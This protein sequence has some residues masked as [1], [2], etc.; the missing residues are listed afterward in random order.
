MEAQKNLSPIINFIWSV[1]DDVLVHAYKKGKYGDVILPMTVIRRLD[2]V[3]EPTKEKV[4]KSHNAYRDRLDNLDYILT[5]EKDGSG[6]Q[7]YNTSKFT[8][9]NLLDD[10]KNIR[11]NF[12]DYLDGFS[13]NVQDIIS[14]FK[15]RNQL[16][17]LE[18]DEDDIHLLFQLIEKFVSPKIDLHPDRLTNHQMGY[19]FE[20]LVRRFNEENNEE[21]GE[22]FTPREIIDLMANIVFLP[23]KDKLKQGSYL[24]YDPCS[25]SGGMLT[26]ARNFINSVIGSDAVVHLYGQEVQAETYATSKSDLLIKG[27]DPEKLGFGSTLTNDKFADIKFDFMMTNPPYGK[28][29]KDDKKRLG[30]GPKGA[31]LDPRFQIGIPRVSDG[32]LM[33]VQHMLSKMKDTPLGSRIASV[34]NGSALFTGDAGQGE[35]EIRRYLFEHDLLEAIIAL[36][37]ELFYNTG[38]PT[39][40]FLIANRKAEERKGKV[41]LINA[42]SKN[43]YHLMRKNLGKKRVELLPEHV[44]KI[45][46][47]YLNFEAGNNVKIFDNEDFGYRQITV[48]QPQ[49]DE[50]GKIITDRSG[51][52]KSDTNL[53][54]TENIPLKENVDEYFERE[55]KPY[56]EN[57]WYSPAE[58]KIGYEV[59]FNKYFYKYKAPRSLKEIAS[60]LE[61]LEAESENLLE[62]ITE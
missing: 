61:K 15:F 10:P 36:P 37:K 42:T 50:D 40:I 20:D 57:A 24:V 32:Q 8:L 60:D 7:F 13:P 9:K 14:K 26:E 39:Y 28:T 17:T 49:L 16:D 52:P 56:S 18:N 6:K 27:D 4:L 48:H 43:F 59:S 11:T 19:V 33:F 46:D 44:Q 2:L 25:G 34:H 5:S 47:L 41:M 31:I 35:S 12:E 45:V 1:A 21:A 38:I 55:V 23:I 54:D 51:K 62:E 22:H 58:T 53:K 30:V 29:W 3:L